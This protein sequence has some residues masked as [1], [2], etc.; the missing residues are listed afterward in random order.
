LAL[1]TFSI[2]RTR[3]CGPKG[4]VKVV[5]LGNVQPEDPGNGLTIGGDDDDGDIAEP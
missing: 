3:S 1:R 2:L 5:H 4:L